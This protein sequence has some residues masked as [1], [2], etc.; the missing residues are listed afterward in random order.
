MTSVLQDGIGTDRLVPRRGFFGRH[1]RAVR[2]RPTARIVLRT[3]LVANMALLASVGT[4]LAL[5]MV[6]PAGLIAAALCGAGVVVL[7][8]LARS[9]ER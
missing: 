1:L 6:R 8:G 4:L 5:F 7:L 9:I 2:L 3:L